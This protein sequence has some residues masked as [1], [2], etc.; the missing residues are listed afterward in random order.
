MSRGRAEAENVH[1][2]TQVALRLRPHGG[3]PRGCRNL[4]SNYD[5]R[6]VT[7]SRSCS[8]SLHFVQQNDAGPNCARLC[9]LTASASAGIGI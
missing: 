5:W 9:T 6:L 2:R 4:C 1:R 7:W 3:N 8:A